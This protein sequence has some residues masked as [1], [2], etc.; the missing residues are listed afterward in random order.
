MKY[1]YTSNVEAFANLFQKERQGVEL[2]WSCCRWALHPACLRPHQSIVLFRT[3]LAQRAAQRAAST[4]PFSSFSKQFP[5][6]FHP[7]A[8]QPDLRCRLVVPHRY[9]FDPRCVGGW[10]GVGGDW[11]PNFWKVLSRLCRIRSL[12]LTAYFALFFKIYK[13]AALLNQ[14]I[15]KCYRFSYNYRMNFVTSQ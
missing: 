1:F 10:Q 11:L 9:S 3:S 6:T 8:P 2:S 4:R 15:F 5:M 12:Q 13:A 7:R 14:S